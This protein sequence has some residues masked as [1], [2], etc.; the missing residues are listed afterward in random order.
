MGKMA[1]AGSSTESQWNATLTWDSHRCPH[2]GHVRRGLPL[3]AEQ[4][5]G[6]LTSSW[7]A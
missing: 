5:M 4:G 7:L 1:R 2:S 6:T 3:C